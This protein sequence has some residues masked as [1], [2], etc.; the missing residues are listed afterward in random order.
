MHSVPKLEVQNIVMEFP[1]V[2]ALAGVSIPFVEAEVNGVIGENGAGKSTLMKILGGVLSPTSGSILLDGKLAALGTVRNAQSHGIAMIHQEMNLV[3]ELTVAENV[4]LGSEPTKRGFLNRAE[5]MSRTESALRQIGAPFSAAARVRDLSLAEKQL[6]E[7]AKAISTKASILIMD[8]P[9][10]VLSEAESRSL[11]ALIARL[12]EQGVTILY[13]SHRLT[14]VCAICDRITVL[15]D[16]Q[17]VTTLNASDT[18]PAKLADLMVGRAMAD[19]YPPKDLHLP[20]DPVLEVTTREN[21]SLRV[22]RGEILGMAGLVGAGRT[23]LGEAIV[24]V[25]GEPLRIRIDGR[26]HRIRS[27]KEAR[28]FGVAYVSEDRKH[29]GLL[30]GLSVLHNITIANLRAYGE[31][32]INRAQ[33]RESGERWRQTLEI[34][35][36]NLD[37]A[38]SSMSGGNQQKVSVAKWLDTNPK[39]LILDEP[40]R[41]VDVGAKRELYD[42]IKRLAAEGMACIVISSDLPELLGVCHRIAVMREGRIVGELLAGQMTEEAAMRMAA[43]VVAA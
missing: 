25:R 38:V 29:L 8:E 33:E 22:E 15:R 42:L 1:S 40:T 6:V 26:E 14:E 13:I 5:M 36:G 31:A 4:F 7:I 9:T 16:G 11:F 39:V 3:E 41:G 18:N 23:E 43:G 20:S 35:V 28:K 37:Q 30:V 10:A 34:R 27:P 21:D 2:R 19:F 32:F 24:G 12:K 17:L